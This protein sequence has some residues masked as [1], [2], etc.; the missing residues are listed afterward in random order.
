MQNAASILYT[1]T[2]WIGQMVFAFQGDFSFFPSS[3]LHLSLRS[4]W[5]FK[6]IIMMFTAANPRQSHRTMSPEELL[7][8]L[9]PRE[10]KAPKLQKPVRA[11]ENKP[12]KKKSQY[13]SYIHSAQWHERRRR[14]LRHHWCCVICGTTDDLRVH[15]VRYTVSG[16]SVL[17]C[18]RDEDL[19]TLCDKCHNKVHYYGYERM[20]IK[21]GLYERMRIELLCRPSVS[22]HRRDEPVVFG[23]PDIDVPWM[24]PDYFF[25]PK[26]KHNNGHDRVRISRYSGKNLY[27]RMEIERA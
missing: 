27:D 24:L 11:K 15:H 18:E 7:A 9:K 8:F 1:C 23:P 26:Q 6:R 2:A 17:G 12:H 19:R 21:K 10:H 3:L 4:L 20:F 16:K 25:D 22:T 14:Y 5:F 13:H